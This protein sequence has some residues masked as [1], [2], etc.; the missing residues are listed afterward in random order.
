MIIKLPSKEE[1]HKLFGSVP[2]GAKI[3]S[4]TKNGMKDLQNQKKQI[5][6]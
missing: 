5:F 3:K 4:T 6:I 2:P 1:R